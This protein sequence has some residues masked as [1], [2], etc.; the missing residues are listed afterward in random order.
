MALRLEL[1][2]E[3]LHLTPLS[4]HDVDLALEMFTDPE[5]VRYVCDVM[6]EDT[7]R[8]GV[9]DSLR[10]GADGWIGIWCVSQRDTGEKIGTIFLLPLPIDED[11][12]DYTLVVPGHTPEGEIEIGYCFK[13]PA[14]GQGFATEACRRLVRFAFEDTP[15]DRIVASFYEE[16]EATKKVLRNAGFTDRGTMWCYGEMSPIYRITRQ[17]WRQSDRRD[18][19]RP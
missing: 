8:A 7:I 16:N 12:T 3:R 11:D 10:R 1:F 6:D 18:D 14:W 2:S 4:S 5:V 9:P 17:E 15:L 19:P 13:R